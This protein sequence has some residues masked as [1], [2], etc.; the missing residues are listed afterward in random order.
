MDPVVSDEWEPAYQ[1]LVI[2]CLDGR[3]T[4]LKMHEI[5]SFSDYRLHFQALEET[6]G[7]AGRGGPVLHASSEGRSDRTGGQSHLPSG[8]HRL[9]PDWRGER[10]V[11]AGHQLFEEQRNAGERRLPSAKTSTGVT[12]QPQID[13]SNDSFEPDETVYVGPDGRVTSGIFVPGRPLDEQQ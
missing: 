4:D 7:E 13:Q 2:D 3:G 8:Q 6:T 1:M 11:A 12:T 10:G 5:V 9:P